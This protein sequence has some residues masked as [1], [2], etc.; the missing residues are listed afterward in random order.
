MRERWEERSDIGKPRSL[1]HR[2]FPAG[3]R[4]RFLYLALRIE[5]VISAIVSRMAR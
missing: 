2:V 1:S 3:F 5:P 4:Q